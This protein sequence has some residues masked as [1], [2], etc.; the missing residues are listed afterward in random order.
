MFTQIS[1]NFE[2]KCGSN[3]S[4]LPCKC[5]SWNRTR[6]LKLQKPTLRPAVAHL[7]VRLSLS[8]RK[9]LDNIELIKFIN[10]YCAFRNFR[11]FRKTYI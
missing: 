6:F 5:Y 8:E 10:K 3:V 9:S 4:D 1:T 2:V 7:L 11:Y